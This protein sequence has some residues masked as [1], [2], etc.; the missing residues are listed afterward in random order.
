V[1]RKKYKCKK[2]KYKPIKYGRFKR[3][4]MTR[5]S[6]KFKLPRD[7]LAGRLSGSRK[8]SKEH[9]KILTKKFKSINIDVPLEYWVGPD[10]LSLRYLIKEWYKE[11]MD[12]RKPRT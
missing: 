9:A 6:E 8:V 2:K 5:L 4:L 7:Q 12:E 1:V 3:G 10:R 11:E